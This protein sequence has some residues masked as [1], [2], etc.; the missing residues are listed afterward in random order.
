M[1]EDRESGAAGTGE[2]REVDAASR[3]ALVL[4]RYLRDLDQ[5][6]LA[7]AAGI[8]PSLIS[9]YD[10]G[11]RT[12]PRRTLAKAAEAVDFPLH[13]LDP[14]LAELRSFLAA[15]RGRP[16]SGRVPARRAAT[17]LA[18]L[19]LEAT[20]VVLAPLGRPLAAAS[21]SPRDRDTAAS[22]WECLLRRTPTERRLLVEELE[23][24]QV[25]PLCERAAAAS[26]EAAPNRPLEALEWAE[27]ALFVAELVSGERAWRSKLQ[28]YAWAHLANARRVMDDLKRAE[29]DLARALVLWQEGGAAGTGLLNEACLPWIEAVL[30]KDQRRFS[31]ALERIEE[32][33]KAGGDLRGRILLSKSSILEIL[34]NPEASIEVLRQAEPLVDEHRDPRL[35]LVLRFNL[36]AALCR[37]GRA[38]EA[39]PRLP[40]VR[41]LAEQLGQELDL[42]RVAWLEGKVAAGLGRTAAAERVFERVR[43]E[44]A[45]RKLGYD[46]ALASLD[47][48]LVLLGEDRVA[49]VRELAAEMLWIFREK[50]IHRE[51]L[52]TLRLFCDAAGREAA[53][54]DLARRVADYLR[55]A[56][57]DPA[58]RF[59]V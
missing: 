53:T 20:D 7:R 36:S 50:R 6:G 21:P 26:L 12:V 30:R 42:L 59:E 18:A 38:A 43:R 31:E 9:E 24:F 45:A 27:L 8:A 44:F 39:E 1:R 14:L 23:E 37:L 47:L 58:L 51:A 40:E 35:A 5:G 56:Q 25:W 52:A 57:G 16:R 32:A 4:L 19:L 22:A 2:E 15:A 49:E 41:A 10:R 29:E 13:L 34:G 55:R 3:L 28:G 17:G 54:T 33:L 11:K 46:C 48:A